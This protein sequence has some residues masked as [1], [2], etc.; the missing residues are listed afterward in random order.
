MENGRLASTER[1]V[2]VLEEARSAWNALQNDRK[3]R[4]RNRNYLMGLQWQDEVETEDGF[5]TEREVIED[6]GREAWKMNH[7]RPIIRNLKGQLRQNQSDR[8]VFAVN[9]E[10]NRAAEVMT[11][12]LRE[13]RRINAM[14]S[15][16]ADQFIEHLLAG[17]SAFHV[18]Y[19]YWPK[20]DRPEV[21]IR[22][23]NMLRFFYNPDADDRRGHDLRIVGEIHD[24]SLDDI[25]TSFAPRDREYGEAIREYYGDVKSETFEMREAF[26]FQDGLS[27]DT[28]LDSDLHRV[29]EVWRRRSKM[30]RKVHDPEAGRTVQAELPDARI[31]QENRARRQRGMEELRVMDRRENVWVGYFL[32]PTGEILWAGETPYDHQEHPYAFGWADMIDGESRGLL[33]DLIDQQRLYNRMIQVMDLGMSTSARGVLMIPEERIP[34]GMSVNDFAEEYTKVNGVVVY[35]ARTEDG[36]QID[37]RLKPEQVYN[38]SIPTGAFEWLA[39]MRED[40]ESSSGVTGPVMGESPDSGTP[41]ALYNAQITQS[42]TTTLDL[43]ETYFEVLRDLDVKTVQVA[44][45]FYDD[46][47]PVRTNEND[48]LRFTSDEVRDVQFDATVAQVA[49]TATYRQLY[50]R[51]LQEMRAAGEITF[52]QYLEMSSHPKADQLIELIERTNPL[53]KGETRPQQGTGDPETQQALEVAAQGSQAATQRNLRAQLLQAAENGDRDAAALLSQAA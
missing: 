29:I 24:M 18:G 6:Q 22:K 16:E 34:E 35:K 20:Y 2:D 13:A 17:K 5:K 51:D 31:E 11:H 25:V 26:G 50:E 21:S 7:I 23:V 14:E 3:R 46:D 19:K 44:A 1:S 42:N 15:I 9:R 27:F 47:R 41:A 43:F 45:Q 8:Q 37:P 4:R 12:V 53:V 49:D 52:R 36:G 10:D 48:I 40:M 32:T 33:S 39:Q 28:P 30:V 38:Q